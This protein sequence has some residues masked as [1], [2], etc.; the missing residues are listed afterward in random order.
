M[1]FICCIQ[2]VVVHGYQWCTHLPLK[3]KALLLAAFLAS[4]NPPATDRT[5]FG[6]SLKGRRKK[7]RGDPNGSSTD[8][9][10]AASMTGSLP[11]SFG[12]ERLLSIYQQI[13]PSVTAATCSMPHNK[14]RVHRTVVHTGE[15]DKHSSIFSSDG[16][17]RAQSSQKTLDEGLVYTMVCNF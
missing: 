11:Q 9:S 14:Y 2:S 15:V 10:K 16:N 3:A 17:F 4:R 8:V 1:H 7:T 12:L 6:N 5:T 13:L